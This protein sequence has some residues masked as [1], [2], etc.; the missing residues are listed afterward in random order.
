VLAS[1]SSCRGPGGSRRTCLSRTARHALFA[2]PRRTRPHRV[3]QRAGLRL[4]RRHNDRRQRASWGPLATFRPRTQCSHAADVPRGDR[5][6]PQASA[7][8]LLARSPWTA[9]SASGA[10]PMAGGPTSR[11][12]PVAA[13]RQQVCRCR[14]QDYRAGAIRV[15]RRRHG[16]ALRFAI[17]ARPLLADRRRDPANSG[18]ID[19]PTRGRRSSADRA[20]RSRRGPG[21]LHPDPAV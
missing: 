6:H 2:A 9:R 20:G 7:G 3:G 18:R 19:P 21:R 15:S 10:R 12:S 17:S 8:G 5:Q 1:C 11:F 14:S 16:T 13:G 4:V